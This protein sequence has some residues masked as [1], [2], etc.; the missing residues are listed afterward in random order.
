MRTIETLLA[1]NKLLTTNQHLLDSD[2]YDASRAQI[3]D[4]NTP[5]IDHAFVSQPVKPMPHE[6]RNR[7]TCETWVKEL[8]DMQSHQV[9]SARQVN[10]T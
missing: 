7:Y 4:R 2:L 8:I 9:R 3:I 6:L 10:E 5:R 1:G